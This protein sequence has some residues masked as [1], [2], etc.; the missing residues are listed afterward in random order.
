MKNQYFGDVNDYKKY[1]LL[2]YLGRSG[3]SNLAVCWSLTED[4]SRSDGS[5]VRY[6]NDPE[7]G[8]P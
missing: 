5:R 3:R 1:G 7:G 4:D 6:L 8:E 2:R